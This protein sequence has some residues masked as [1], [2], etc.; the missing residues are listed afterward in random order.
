MKLINKI[1]LH[2]FKRFQN[3]SVELD[4]KLNI[5]IGDNESGKSSILSAIDIVLSG[6]RSKVETIGL[7]NLFNL[8]TINDFLNSEKKVE[9]LPRLF[10]EVYLN[11]QS[12]FDLNGKVNSDERICDGLQLICEPDDHLSKEIKDILEQ[13]EPNFPFEYYLIIFK[14]FSGE[15]YTGYRKYLKHILID[16]TQISNEYATREYVKA[17]YNSNVKNTEKNKHQNEYGK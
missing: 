13:K 3:F 8:T 5:L 12:N 2:N 9:N 7:D 10:I 11:D 15:S 4:N 6:S 1:K 14:T 16:N 17:I